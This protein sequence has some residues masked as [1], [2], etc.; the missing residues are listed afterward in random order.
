MF[1][2]SQMQC[3]IAVKITTTFELNVCVNAVQKP[4]ET[5]NELSVDVLSKLLNQLNPNSDNSAK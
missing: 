3:S 2:A 5:L 1:D 4:S